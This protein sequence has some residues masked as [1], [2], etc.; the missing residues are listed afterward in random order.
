MPE[1]DELLSYL[2]EG[3]LFSTLDLSNW[4]LQIPLTDEAK[5]KTAFVIGETAAKFESMPFGLKGSSGMF[6]KPMNLL[7]KE[8]KDAGVIHIYLDDIIIPLF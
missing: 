6:Q 4:F 1:I 7:F 3:K 5:E 2:A 8:L